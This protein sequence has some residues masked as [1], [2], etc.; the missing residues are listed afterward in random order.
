M[1]TTT[2]ATI[3]T[4]LSGWRLLMTLLVIAGATVLSGLGSWQWSRLNQRLAHNERINA[5][6]SAA[7]IPL[8]SEAIDPETFDYQWVTVR[9]MFDPTQEILLRSRSYQ[10][11]TGYNIITPLRLSG[12][13]SAVL[14]NRGW[15]PL[16]ERAPE[17]RSR[18]APP[19][20]EVMIEGVARRSQEPA[21]DGP[22]DPPLGPDR[23]RLDAWFRVT[24]PRIQ[25]QIDYPLLPVFVEQQPEPGAPALP[26]RQATTD[27]GPGSHMSYALQW[28]SFAIILVVGYV[29]LM[30]QQ[31][32]R[33][34]TDNRRP[35][36]EESVVSR[37]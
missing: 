5:R 21:E 9:G 4:M 22:Q 28:Y 37:P 34:T 24:I 25:E 32:K 30:R 18:F 35:T 13:D 29:V 26:A 19:T 10:G 16:T 12:S 11:A 36:T 27:L 1:M 8:D 7:P 6:L 2:T 15:I 20:G 14:V 23:P 33:V 17:A 3:K 31:A